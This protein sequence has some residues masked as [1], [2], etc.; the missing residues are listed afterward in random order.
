MASHIGDTPRV[1]TSDVVVPAATTNTKADAPPSDTLSAWL[2]NRWKQGFDWPV[3]A[4]ITALHVGA[5]AA[6]FFFTWKSVLLAVVL[7]YLTGGIGICLG[8]HRMLTHSSFATFRP[9]RWVIALLGGLAGQGSPLMWVANHHKHHA[10]S[11]QEGDHHSPNDGAWWSH[12]LWLFPRLTRQHYDTLYKKYAPD[13]MKDPFR[14]LLDKTFLVWYFALGGL[15]FTIGYFGWDFYTGVSFVIYGMFVRLVYVLHTTW[16]VNSATH[17][18]GYRN[19]ETSDES[20]NLW[21][22]GLLSFGEGWHNNHH[23]F[24]RVARHGHRWWGRHD[25]LDDLRHG[26]LGWPGTSRFASPQGHT[27]RLTGGP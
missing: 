3:I 10:F 12:M 7:A 4:W 20:R 27:Y 21:W 11:D 13:L 16:F 18:W 25:L 19:Y 26:K 14:R 2:A 22:V 1:T 5:L 9:V 8:Y 17:I 24:Q 23:A 6:P 15:L